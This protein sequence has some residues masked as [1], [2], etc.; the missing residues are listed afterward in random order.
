MY[1][2]KY[3]RIPDSK[4]EKQETD[5]PEEDAIPRRRKHSQKKPV[6]EILPTQQ[7][8]KQLDDIQS[9]S[10]NELIAYC[11]GSKATR[12]HWDEFYN[13]YNSL[14]E[15]RIE[16]TLYSVGISKDDITMEIADEISLAVME[17][18]LDGKSLKIIAGYHYAK[19]GLGRAV[20]NIVR[21]WNRA[22][23]LQKH[24][25][26]AHVRKKMISIHTP[27]GEE[28]DDDECLLDIIADPKTN[29]IPGKEVEATR[30]IAEQVI[31]EIESLKDATKRL[32]VKVNILF[33]RPLTD[34]DIE[35]ISS[36]RSVM[37]SE[38][39]TEVDAIAARLAD[40]NEQIERQL[41]RRANKFAVLE[42]LK[43]QLDGMRKVSNAPQSELRR[44]E[45]DIA[46]KAKELKNL[47]KRNQKVSVYPSAKEVT[48]LLNIPKT[49][50][51]DI[52]VWLSRFR[53]K[54]EKLGCVISNK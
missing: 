41:D 10:H 14:I 49:K 47:N 4:E 36:L 35:E 22:R 52:A 17:K 42:G 27:L 19:A 7:K 6:L 2:D 43:R 26:N 45:R 28:E 50:K 16:V 5:Q 25:Y 1:V 18:F 23:H 51:K 11:A 37:P 33:Y 34:K 24:A 39:E 8:N 31:D 54:F 38:I 15:K 53:E 13:R 46:R 9:L 30:E 44:M 40:K 29:P 48:Q 3:R 32:A 12:R 21:S 20:E